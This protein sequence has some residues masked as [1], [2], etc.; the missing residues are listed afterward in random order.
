MKHKQADVG[1]ELHWDPRQGGGCYF[2]PDQA[3][4]GVTVHRQRSKE[5]SRIP[6]LLLQ[7]QQQL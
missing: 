5:L 6:P 3:G 1:G 2:V 4:A 7:Q